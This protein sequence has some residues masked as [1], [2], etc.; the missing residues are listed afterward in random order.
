MPNPFEKFSDA[1]RLNIRAQILNALNSGKLNEAQTKSAQQGLAA[2]DAL[3]AGPEGVDANPPAIPMKAPPMPSARAPEPTGLGDPENSTKA[4][5]TE[6]QGTKVEARAKARMRLR[7]ISPMLAF[8]FRDTVSPLS[9]I[10]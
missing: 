3:Q 8:S 5:A 4:Q 6:R 1:Q 10:G 9:F 2:L 7:V